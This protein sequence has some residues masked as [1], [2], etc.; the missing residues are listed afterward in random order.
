[1]PILKGLYTYGLIVFTMFGVAKMLRTEISIPQFIF[2]FVSPLL[3]VLM[4]FCGN[5]F[6]VCGAVGAL[7]LS[8]VSIIFPKTMLQSHFHVT[9]PLL[10][11][12][13]ALGLYILVGNR[14]GGFAN[15]VKMNLLLYCCAF[16][17]GY[18]HWFWTHHHVLRS[19]CSF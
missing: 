14:V 16:G 17:A 3:V 13:S 2:A 6:S 12:C 19:A 8:F 9:T 1:M 7:E 15:C 18:L 10:I 5:A 11:G 4:Y